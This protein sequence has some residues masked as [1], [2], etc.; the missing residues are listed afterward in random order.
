MSYLSSAQPLIRIALL[1]SLAAFGACGSGGTAGTDTQNEVVEAALGPAG[2]D[3]A[4]SIRGD[5]GVEIS[6]VAAIP[7]GGCVVG[8]V[9]LGPVTTFGEPGREMKFDDPFGTGF[10]AH[11]R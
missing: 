2:F 5:R 3:G 11:Y 6:A 7:G 4:H 9:L 8:G 10:V 1:A